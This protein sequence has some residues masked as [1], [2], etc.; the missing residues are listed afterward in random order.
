MGSLSWCGGVKKP[1]ALMRAILEWS[2]GRSRD[3]LRGA[4]LGRRRDLAPDGVLGAKHDFRFGS[5]RRP[6][7]RI[8]SRRGA[9]AFRAF[10]AGDLGATS[11]DVEL[12]LDWA[13]P[14]QHAIADTLRPCPAARSSRTASSRRSPGVRARRARRVRSARRTGSRSSSRATA[15]SRRTASAATATRASS[16]KR[17]LLALEGVVV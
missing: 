14:L 6:E 1:C 5:R 15:S 8:R 10:L 13:T 2:G 7:Q 4:R 16:V 17:R 11:S 3:A 9:S 12:D